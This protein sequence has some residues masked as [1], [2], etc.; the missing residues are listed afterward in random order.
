DPAAA[1]AAAWSPRGTASL[2]SASGAPADLSPH[3]LPRPAD[4]P[5]PARRWSPAPPAPA[6]RPMRA[7]GERAIPLRH[8]Y[9]AAQPA[10]N[11]AAPLPAPRSAAWS[12]LRPAPAPPPR[13][14]APGIARCGGGSRSSGPAGG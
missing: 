11:S 13:A 3:G 9:A 12:V 1:L 5:S 2:R 14:A 7:A 4:A 8:D 10:G 6:D